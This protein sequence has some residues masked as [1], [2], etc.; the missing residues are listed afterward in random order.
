MLF[1]IYLLLFYCV[2]DKLFVLEILICIILYLNI[3][4]KGIFLVSYDKLMVCLVF[5]IDCMIEEFCSNRL[6]VS[7]NVVL[8]LVFI[9]VGFFKKIRLINCI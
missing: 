6:Y 1:E 5:V 8:C 3:R 4:F 9:V 7:G 2:N